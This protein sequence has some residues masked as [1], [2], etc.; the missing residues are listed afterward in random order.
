VT[1][2]PQTFA[3]RNP[4]DA[5]RFRP[6]QL[7]VLTALLSATALLSL[8]RKLSVLGADIFWHLKTGD[9]ILQ[10][11]AFPRLGLFSRTAADRPW[12][13]YSWG[14]EVLL[15]RAYSWAGLRG[16]AIYGAA[17]TV[18]VAF[19]IFWMTRRLSGRFYYSGLLAAIACYSFQLFHVV[20]RPAFFSMAWFALVLLVLFDAQRTGRAQRLTWLPILFLL[21]ANLH[22]QFVYGLAA[23]ALLLAINLAQ[24][25][26]ERVGLPTG[27]LTPRQLPT[28]RLAIIFVLCVM[29]T[30]VGPYSYELYGII[31]RYSQ[32]KVPYSVV[33]ELQPFAL[34]GYAS[35]L[36]LLVAVA[37]FIA[38]GWQKRLDLFKLAL[39]VLT[40]AFALRTQRDAWFQCIAAAACIAGAMR[41]DE[42][43]EPAETSLQ[44]AGVLVAVVLIA[45]LGAPKIAFSEHALRRAMSNYFPID[46]A[47]YIQQRALPGPLWNPFDWGGFL[48]WYLPDYPVAI[49]GRTDLYGDAMLKR[50]QETQNGATDYR[51]DP[52]LAESRVVLTRTRDPLARLLENDPRY[53]ELYSDS[54]AT[55]FAR[56]IDSD[57][58]SA[59]ASR[60][61]FGR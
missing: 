38:V 30:L 13:A 31:Y 10:H 48:V 53:D 14:Y 11:H 25:I 56:V 15:A 43:A 49:D 45:T 57:T 33:W 22:I 20:P 21:W 2:P 28:A 4:L 40:T 17:L 24:Q 19:S 36:Q 32:A 34:R 58:A 27:Y 9:W 16:I 44:L 60:P 7:A 61:S 55:V 3:S 26:A 47:D 50:F 41:E 46:A 8:H 6:L 51:S 23:V 37:A 5:N 18:L 29:A 59:P 54:I 1:T 42:L 35:Y 12:L 52:Y 39:L